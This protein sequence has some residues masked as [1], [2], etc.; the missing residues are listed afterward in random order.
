MP[1]TIRNNCPDCGATIG[2]L[3]LSNCDIE[4]CPSCGSQYLSCDCDINNIERIKWDGYWPGVKE[5]E[6]FGMFC[7]SHDF[8]PCDK[9]TPGAIH[10]LNMLYMKTTWDKNKQKR[11]LKDK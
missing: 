4:R 6:E 2:N 1:E 8:I 7:T 3:H 10:D 11:I 9:N 5:C